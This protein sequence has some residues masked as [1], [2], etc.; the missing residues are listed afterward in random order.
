[1][2]K[3]VI[4]HPKRDFGYLIKEIVQGQVRVPVRVSILCSTLCT[5]E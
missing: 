3:R 2:K 1:M 4:G 5:K